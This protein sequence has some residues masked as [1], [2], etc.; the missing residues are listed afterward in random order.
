MNKQT[1]TH[2]YNLKHNFLKLCHKWL[3]DTY[4]HLSQIWSRWIS[5]TTEN[6]FKYVYLE[7]KVLKFVQ[8]RLY[9]LFVASLFCQYAIFCVVA[10]QYLSAT[11]RVESRLLLPTVYRAASK[12]Q[13]LLDQL[14][15][16]PEG[17]QL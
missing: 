5:L 13:R 7:L 4:T 1:T 12:S 8:M 9:V 14:A 11:L 17:G 3:S 15:A 16:L 2:V 10:L 6:L